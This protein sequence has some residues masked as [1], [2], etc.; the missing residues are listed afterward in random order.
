MA[1][2]LQKINKY[3]N[4]ILPFVLICVDYIAIIC[5]EELAFNF[6]NFYIGNHSL[7]ISWLNFWVV[8]PLL[9]LIFLNIEQLYNRRAQ[10]WQIIQKLFIT[11][12]YAVTAIIILLYIAHSRLNQQNVHRSILA[13][14]F[15]PACNLPLYCQKSA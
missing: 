14:K 15:Y 7:H 10:F 12:C 11:S 8:F 9:Y 1:E 2:N 6:R 4:I 5:A 3:T 13:L